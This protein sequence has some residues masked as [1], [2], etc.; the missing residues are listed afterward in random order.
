MHVNDNYEQ[1]SEHTDTDE[2]NSDQDSDIDSRFKAPL[3]N[4]NI[5]EVSKRLS[6]AKAANKEYE[7]VVANWIEYKVKWKNSHNKK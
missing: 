7:R 6:D 3:K 4:L 1:I 2:D 5:T